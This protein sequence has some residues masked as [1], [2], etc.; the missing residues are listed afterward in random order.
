MTDKAT[1]AQRYLNCAPGFWAAYGMHPGQVRR[2]VLLAIFRQFPQAKLPVN[3]KWQANLLDPDLRYFLKKGVLCRV[4]EGQVKPAS[5]Q[6]QTY[7][8]L[9]EV[10]VT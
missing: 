10:G 8:V 4:R 6:R 5:R 1:V 7:L 2:Q 9:A 3:R